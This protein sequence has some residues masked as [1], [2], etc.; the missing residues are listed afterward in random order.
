MDEYIIVDRLWLLTHRSAISDALTL[1]PAQ[2]TAQL[3]GALASIDTLLA[4]A[5]EQEA[6]LA[7]IGAP[8]SV[9]SRRQG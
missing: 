4:N 2:Q 6:Q 3:W 7:M 9:R 1:P 5:A 8:L